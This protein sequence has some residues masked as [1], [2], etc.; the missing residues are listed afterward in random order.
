MATSKV[1][2]RLIARHA[3]AIEFG[4]D[5]LAVAEVAHSK[6]SLISIA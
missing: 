1:S 6:H 2:V 4:F 3:A 5:G